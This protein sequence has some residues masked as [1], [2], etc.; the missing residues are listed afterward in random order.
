MIPITATQMLTIL[1]DLQKLFTIK[2]PTPGQDIFG[3]IARQACENM[4]NDIKSVGVQAKTIQDTKNTNYRDHW[5]VECINRITNMPWSNKVVYVSQMV[6]DINFALCNSLCEQNED[7]NLFDTTEWIYNDTNDDE[8]ISEF[9][10]ICEVASPQYFAIAYVQTFT[11]TITILLDGDTDPN[12]NIFNQQIFLLTIMSQLIESIRTQFPSIAINEQQFNFKNL[13]KE[14]NYYFKQTQ[15]LTELV[16]QLDI[17]SNK[18]QIS[19]ITN[20]MYNLRMDHLI[21]VD[22]NQWKL[23]LD[24]ISTKVKCELS[25]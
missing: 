5:T 14:F 13:P 4:F 10:P 21:Q 18:T 6:A 3:Y 22:K 24:T 19:S 25:Y 9:A 11:S 8:S 1:K 12:I 23:F 15:Y 2:H 16:N 20:S 7:H 17:K